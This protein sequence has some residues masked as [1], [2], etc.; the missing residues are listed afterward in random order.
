MKEP[1]NMTAGLRY[2]AAAL[3]PELTALRTQLHRHPE[4][5]LD[6]PNTQA[7]VL[8]ALDGVGL[9]ITLGTGLSS[10]VAVL[11]GGRPGPAVLLRG[12]MDVLP[13]V[14]D[15]GENFSS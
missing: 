11:R 5:G 15:S 8:A 14:E 3:A 1:T 13:V 2:E 12:D 7:A 4:L 6:L 9:D 10:V